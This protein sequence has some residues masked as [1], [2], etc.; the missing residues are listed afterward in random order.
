MKLAIVEAWFPDIV[1]T[2]NIM[3]RGTATTT[4]NAIK[5]AFVNIFKTD[6]VKRRR[7]TTIKATITVTEMV[8]EAPKKKLTS[9][10]VI[11]T[12]CSSTWKAFKGKI[13]RKCDVCGARDTVTEK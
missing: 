10:D 6:R 11:C 9:I 7:F 12:D 3:A 1:G 8:D 4:P 2:P 13:P 5:R